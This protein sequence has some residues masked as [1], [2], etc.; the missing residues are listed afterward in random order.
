MARHLF[1]VKYS[2]TMILQNA[3]PNTPSFFLHQ[4]ISHH[5][6]VH[7]TIY[8]DK[9]TTSKI[10]KSTWSVYY[11]KTTHICFPYIVKQ[12]LR[13]TST[14]KLLSTSV[15]NPSRSRYSSKQ[16]AADCMFTNVSNHSPCNKAQRYTSV[17]LFDIH[18][19]PLL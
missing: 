16:I 6:G 12:D 19:L 2:I 1:L 4:M 9:Q 7:C 8:T 15:L 5:T 3:S 11:Y 17:H 18:K 10:H 13:L 14:S